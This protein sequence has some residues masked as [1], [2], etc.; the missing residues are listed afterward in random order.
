MDSTLKTTLL[1][2]VTQPVIITVVVVAIAWITKLSLRDDMGLRMPAGRVWV[3]WLVGWLV[4]TV[5]EDAVTTRL[6]LTMQNDGRQHGSLLFALSALSA[7]VL[8]PISEELMLR[9]L[10]FHPLRKRLGP[11]AAI[12]ITAA[13]Y[14]LMHHQYPAWAIALLTGHGVVYG[15]VRYRSGSV[16][17]P[18]A[19]HAIG[20]LYGIVERL[21]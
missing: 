11:V 18:V 2:G 20:N 13:I 9:G 14:G 12:G 15:W 4:W 3:A 16:L 19:M 5:I 10:A 7:V 17:M 1:Y 8:Y 6:G 21:L